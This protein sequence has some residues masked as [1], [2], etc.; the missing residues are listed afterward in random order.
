[1]KKLILAVL[2]VVL[3]AF[4]ANAGIGVASTSIQA[5]KSSGGGMAT[6][7]ITGDANGT[8]SAGVCSVKV[9][10]ATGT[11]FEVSPTAQFDLNIINPNGYYQSSISG[12]SVLF[13]N[14]AGNYWGNIQNTGADTWALG[15]RSSP[16]T[17]LGTADFSW[18][19]F[20]ARS[21]RDFTTN[22]P[23]V[24]NSS[25]VFTNTGGNPSIATSSD[26]V[27]TGGVKA[28]W[29]QGRIRPVDVDLSTVTTALSGKQATGSYITALTGD[30]TASGPGS[31]ALS[32][33]HTQPGSVDFSTITTALNGK[34]ATTGTAVA[35]AAGGVDFSTITTALAGK[36]A[37]GS[38]GDITALTALTAGGLAD[39]TIYGQDIA[40]STVSLNKLYSSGANN[41][42]VVTYD[43][44]LGRWKPAAVTMPSTISTVV[45][46][47][48]D[49]VFTG[50]ASSGTLVN[51]GT[52]TQTKF[53]VAQ[54]TVTMTVNGTHDI[55]FLFNCVVG[56]GATAGSYGWTVEIDGAYPSYNSMGVQKGASSCL[57]Y[58]AA[59]QTNCSY[60]FIL[61]RG[62]VAAGSHTFAVSL[63]DGA[64]DT[65]TYPAAAY[66]SMTWPCQWWARELP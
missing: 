42:D 36:A 54:A 31:A 48:S 41:N 16:S 44:S 45:T 47:S 10:S 26:V 4:S 5:S 62:K 1:M 24:F 15:R 58:G 30:G 21:E 19:T 43:S 7:T 52:I 9:T 29:L 40:L 63:A 57:G 51:P 6:G 53:F 28:D 23:A 18:G 60:P 8:C 61:P 59:S 37:S 38:N 46:F 3:G 33:T 25:A 11:T 2:A 27:V 64:N 55:E 22:G 50:L 65:I 34:L 39:G 35:V 20:G 13:M 12:G 56:V 32:I 17:A 66:Q 14:S 49:V